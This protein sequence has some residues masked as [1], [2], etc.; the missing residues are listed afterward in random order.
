MTHD[1][2]CGI[3][4]LDDRFQSA[5]EDNPEFCQCKFFQKIR[6]DE[7]EQVAREIQD[8]VDP[9]VREDINAGLTWAAKIARGD[10]K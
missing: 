1:K 3:A 5:L 10:S 2:F 4:Q 7:R 9:M 8:Y 6:Q